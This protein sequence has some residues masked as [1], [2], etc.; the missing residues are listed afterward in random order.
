[1]V[2]LGASLA[3]VRPERKPLYVNVINEI[4]ILE[5]WELVSLITLL[6]CSG[7]RLGRTYVELA[8]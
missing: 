2:S 4:Y 8:P 7:F 5:M 1:M 3:Y 6:T